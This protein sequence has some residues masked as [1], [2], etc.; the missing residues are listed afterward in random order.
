MAQE[1]FQLEWLGGPAEHHYR[2]ARPGLDDLPWGTVETARYSP[3]LLAAAQRTWTQVAVNEYSAAG[4]FTH[5]VRALVQ[6]KAPLDL[7]GMASG[8][9][10]DEVSH[11]ELASRVAMELGGATPISLDM[12]RFAELATTGTTALE[13]ANELVMRVSLISETFSGAT[14]VGSMRASTHPLLRAV[15]ERILADES[16]HMRLGHLYFSWLGD[17]LSAEEG[18]RLSHIAVKTLQGLSSFWRHRISKVTDGVTEEGYP[19]DDIHSLGWLESASF[20]PLARKVAEQEILTP[21]A[22]YGIEISAH[23]RRTLFD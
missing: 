6:A 10:T 12:D 17:R 21:L 4:Q 9:L 1:L 16:L 19:V 14:S 18:R 5:V 2:K 22:R 7:I 20:V 11:V 8:F 15:H 3:Q 13:R 23:D